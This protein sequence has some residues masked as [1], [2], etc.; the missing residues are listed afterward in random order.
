MPGILTRLAVFIWLTLVKEDT[1]A[2]MEKRYHDNI[3]D[4]HG[5]KSIEGYLPSASIYMPRK[6]SSTR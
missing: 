5:L 2:K 4:V 1:E 6:P 3:A